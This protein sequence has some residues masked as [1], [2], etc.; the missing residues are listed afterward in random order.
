[1][2]CSI[3]NPCKKCGSTEARKSGD[4]APC[5]R[6]AAQRYRERNLEKCKERVNAYAERNREKNRVRAA[7]YQQ[8]NKAKV[9]KARA[10][11]YAK[12]KEYLNE[13]AAIYRSENREKVNKNSRK[14]EKENPEAK[15]RIDQNRRARKRNS[16]G[17]LS[18][19]IVQKL[20]VL[21]K[22]ICPCC[23]RKLGNDYHVDHIFPL[24]LG[25]PN[26]DANVQLLRAECNRKKG[27]KHPVDFMQKQGF[28][29]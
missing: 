3:E 13:M 1:M 12:N 18:R 26:T 27:A 23:R 7:L 16:G 28:L 25:G 2:R 14:W 8:E 9:T 15:R 21:Q 5:N 22:G 19:D 29:L 24:A 11:Y 17:V 20:M 10:I 4:C 6:A